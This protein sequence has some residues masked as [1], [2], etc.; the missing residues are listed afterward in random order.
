MS[1]LRGADGPLHLS[2]F[3]LV[4]KLPRI[5]P[6]GFAWVYMGFVFK[7]TPGPFCQGLALNWYC[8]LKTLILHAVEETGR[9]ALWYILF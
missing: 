6:R 3:L 2:L 7:I 9:K 5:A 8:D 4:R 1:V